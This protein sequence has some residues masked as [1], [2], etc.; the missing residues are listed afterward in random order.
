MAVLHRVLFT[1]G[2]V[3]YGDLIFPSPVERF[4][5][6]Y[7]Y[8][9]WSPYGSFSALFALPRL[10]TV[11]FTVG[12]ASVLNISM[13]TFAKAYLLGCLILIGLSMYY[14][15]NTLLKE[16]GKDKKTAFIAAI[17][18]A[19]VYM[20]NPW[21][22]AR[23]SHIWLL[24]GYALTPLLL[25]CF[26][27][28]LKNHRIK[29]FIAVALLWVLISASP[30]YA[31]FAGML[32]LS[33]LA[34]SILFRIKTISKSEVLNNF[35]STLLIILFYCIF[36]AF[37]I[38]PY[39]FSS[40]T[41]EHV[42][43]ETYITDESLNL[44]SRNSNVLN[45]IRL[46]G[47]WAVNVNYSPSFQALFYP[48][49]FASFMLPLFA[50]ASLLL[51][52]KN[53]YALYFSLIGF[54]FIF[55]AKG[56]QGPLPSSYRWLTFN[57]PF[58]EVF[59]DP[60][61]WEGL[62]ALAFC[63]MMS[64]TI[65]GLLQ[66]GWKNPNFNWKK[67]IAVLLIFFSFAFF[68]APSVKGWFGSN[69]IPIKIPEEYYIVNNW[70]ANQ[71][72]DFKVS[73]LP[74]YRGRGTTWGSSITGPFEI[75]SSNRPNLGHIEPST[76]STAYYYEY[77]YS[78][79]LLGNKTVYFGKYLNPTN[80]RY[81][82]FHDDIVGAE[83]EADIA[84]ANFNEQKDLKFVKQEGFYYIFEDN[85]YAPFIFIPPQNLLVSGGL[86]TLTSLNAIE[87]FD[88]DS[89][90]LLYLD[91]VRLNRYFDAQGV[92]LG[93]KNNISDIAL[94]QVSNQYLIAPFAYTTRFNPAEAWSRTALNDVWT[95]FL[96][97]T[98]PSPNPWN[99]DYGE[100]IVLTYDFRPSLGP[101][102]P[103]LINTDDV[104]VWE[105]GPW[106]P[107][108]HVKVSSDGE[109]LVVDY[110]FDNE[111][112]IQVVAQTGFELEDWSNY[113]TLSLW[114]YGDGSG[115]QLE[116]WY[117]TN[118]GELRS[119]SIGHC[120]LGWTG[121]KELS[122]TFPAGP[123]NKVLWFQII[124]NWNKNWSQQGLGPHQIKIKDIV[125]SSKSDSRPRH[126]LIIPIEI[127]KSGYH[128]LYARVLENPQG[129]KLTILID[130]EKASSIVT[131]AKTSNFVWKKVGVFNL[132][133]GEH[134]ITLINTYGFNAVNLLALMP[135]EVA[136][137][138]FGN[139]WHFVEGKRLIYI[140]EMESDF[141]Y[142][143]GIIS[144]FLGGKASRG[145]VLVLNK[146]HSSF[147]TSRLINTDNV[148]VWEAGPWTP[149]DHVEV[150]SDGENLIIN[151]TF[152]NENSIQVVAQ[153]G[154]ELE[155]WSNY[156]TLSLW[157]YGDG[158]GNQLEFWYR[159]NHGELRSWSIG[160]YNLDWTGWKEL[161]FTFPAGP[162]SKVIW[163]QLIVNWNKNRSQQG[164]DSHQIRIKDIKLSLENPS[165]ANT[166]IH[167]LRD[168]FYK[169]GVRALTGPS[170]KSM[171]IGIDGERVDVNLMGEEE[172]L[173]WVY[174]GVVFL[175]TGKH[176]LQIL[177]KG[178]TEIDSIVVYSVNDDENLD[179]IFR[180]GGS[181]V[182]ISWKEID[183]TKYVVSVDI[184]RPFM[185]AFAE[186]YDPL[187][188]ASVNGKEY[189]SLPL[190][191][192]INGFW[193]ED[194]GELEITIEYKPQRW[195][196]YGAPIS[197]IGLLGILVYVSKKELCKIIG[198]VKT[199]GKYFPTSFAGREREQ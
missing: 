155:D 25:V 145:E 7:T 150:S 198:S 122:F 19:L 99:F 148:G 109:S 28:A 53:K 92:I 36:S 81:V 100:G 47:Y 64:F 181:P 131:S 29:D 172:N 83:E 40:A 193:I 9:L 191:S 8:P 63:F 156:D 132:S 61:K 62:L 30:A 116:F 20:L 140:L 187:W 167:I 84:I 71:S 174:S 26:I 189:K 46:M 152:D 177:P 153:T 74:E 72:G 144:N 160:H 86:D 3:M 170:H 176:V 183:S 76:P 49:L 123:R 42:Y 117:R 43:S 173:K 107:Q 77:I 199:L 185:L 39:V 192:V 34:F 54:L 55:L 127:E 37:W 91:Q 190:Y 178:K 188:T 22:L 102:P 105:A 106:T 1:N 18:A 45:V 179:D 129:G 143:N 82:L 197:V 124:V 57:V 138:Y 112:S 139:A 24:L 161:S 10:P 66:R 65:Q 31:I 142:G 85:D 168:S 134:Y 137:E 33:W 75:W 103:H 119:W 141:E 180:L 130:G 98:S 51:N 115:N 166:S 154:F 48:W 125:L 113:D 104:G 58:F 108:D 68:I 6:Y 14:A 195:F 194:T 69:Y 95:Y 12:T 11:A 56:V 94:A 35:R 186:A 70:L 171:E 13:E 52:P 118:H 59:R 67:I 121:W 133:K 87:A 80:T 50:F 44:F 21:S 101:V 126:A 165:W 5:S 136:R 163:F 162:R 110:S 88:P 89:F 146:S 90:G 147:V 184:Q 114:A 164:L 196:Y 60:N 73:W 78:E 23:F 15:T 27:K 128:E 32:I 2:L 149:Q 120:T 175:Q 16:Y 17:I 151:Y 96:R 41:P 182:D 93:S 4:L 111:N 38:V 135:Q 158:S 157:A 79:S 97:H 169:I 159:T